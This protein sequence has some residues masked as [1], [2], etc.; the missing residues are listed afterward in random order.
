MISIFLPKTSRAIQNNDRAAVERMA[1]EGTKYTSILVAVLCFPVMLSAKELLM[2]Y[3]GPEYV[4]LALWLFLWVFTLTL[5]LHNSPVSSL[6]LATGKTKMLVFSTAI[7]SAISIVINALLTSKYGVGSAVIGYLTYIIIQV[8]FYYLYFNSKVL[9]LKS[10]RV[11]KSFIIPTCLGLVCFVAVYFIKIEI[12]LLILKI[13]VKT[14]IWG[15]FYLLLLLCFKVVDL[16][17]LISIFQSGR[18]V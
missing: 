10:M 6:V 4:H 1:Y 2:L 11:F 5:S 14:I 8:S 9:G 16:R 15:L 3:V 7:A 12:D 18:V 13:V 17:C